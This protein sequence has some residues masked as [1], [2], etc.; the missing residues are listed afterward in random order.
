MLRFSG[1]L[2]LSNANNVQIRLSA[3]RLVHWNATGSKNCR[4][5]ND[6]ISFI[7]VMGMLR[8]QIESIM[9]LT[10]CW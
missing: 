10:F 5:H 3:E 8:A 9:E 7:L 4:L 2:I 1:L 6:I